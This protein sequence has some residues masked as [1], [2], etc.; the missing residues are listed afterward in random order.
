M[1]SNNTIAPTSFTMT[2][3]IVFIDS[4]VKD[5]QFLA[6]GILPSIEIVILKSDRDGIEQITEILSRRNN[7][8]SIHI[9]SHGSPG[10]LYIGNTQFSLDTLNKYQSQLKTWFSPSPQIPQ[11]PSL[12][13]YGCN[14]AAGDA[15]E[16]FITKLR[17]ITG[18]EIAA[19]TTPIGNANK[20]G[21]W[22]LDSQTTVIDTPLAFNLEAQQNYAGILA[23]TTS[24]S[25]FVDYNND[26]DLDV[27]D[28]PDNKAAE[29]VGYQGI[30]VIA[31]DA[32][33]NVVA[34][35]TTDADGNYTLIT[36]DNTPLRVEFD[37]LPEG[38]VGSSIAGNNSVTETFFIDGTAGS[39]SIA[40]LGIHRPHEVIPT[41]EISGDDLP[42]VD[43]VTVC[44]VEGIGNGAS[45]II[46]HD[47][48]AKGSDSSDPPAPQYEQLVTYDQI[49][50]VNGLAYH[51]Q[52][53]TLF[54]GSF[55]KR[56]S[57]LLGT[58][59]FINNG[60]ANDTSNDEN[61]VAYT[62][63]LYSIDRDTGNVTEFA[64]L[65]DV[66]DPRGAV[67]DSSQTYW[68]IDNGAD[69]NSGNAIFNAVGKTGL[70]DVE[71]S[72]DGNTLWTVNL[73]DN[74]LY[75][76]PVDDPNNP[77]PPSA[78][79]IDSFDVVT[80]ILNNG[81]DLGVNP[82]QNIRP[83]ALSTR[84]GLVY[85]G[86]VNSAQYDTNGDEGNTTAADMRAYVYAIDPDNP[87][88][89]PQKVLDIP[90]DYARDQ[91][92]RAGNTSIPADWNPW[93]SEYPNPTVLFG[94]EVSYPQPMLTDIDFDPEG[95]MILGFRDRFGDQMGNG[96]QP[97]S[98][99]NLLQATSAGDILL[100]PYDNNTDSWTI[101]THVTTDGINGAN[102]PDGE[103]FRNEFLEDNAANDSLQVH[104]ETAQ[105]GLTVVPGFT[106]VVTTAMDPTD[107]FQGGLEWFNTDEETGTFAGHFVNEGGLT[108]SG[109]EIFD[110]GD[111]GAAGKANGL[112]DLEFIADAAKV[113]IGNR[114]WFDLDKDGIQDVGEGGVDGVTVEL[115][116]EGG[117]RL[118][119]TITTNGQ[120]SFSGLSPLTDYE[121]RLVNADF[122]A[123]GSL[124][125]YEP[126]LAN[127]GTNDELDSDAA[128]KGGSGVPVISFQT[129][130]PGEND[131]S[132]DI[133]LTNNPPTYDYGDAPDA[134]SG[135]GAGNY[136]TTDSDNGARHIIA[137]GLTIGNDV[138]VDDGTLQ[139]TDADADLEQGVTFDET[140]QR[141][142]GSFTANV[143]VNLAT[144][145]SDDFSSGGYTGGI[146]WL[147]NWTER[148]DSRTT[149]T[150]ESNND[151]NA[152]VV[153]V[154]DG[155]L[156]IADD[157]T[158]IY[159]QVD[160]SGATGDAILTFNYSWDSLD[161]ADEQYEVI[162]SD[163]L[164]GN[165]TV[166]FTIDD[167]TAQ[168][169]DASGFA[170]INIPQQFLTSTT[171][172][173]IRKGTDSINL[174]PYDYAY[175]D[176]F[177]I[178]APGVEVPA[179]LA[180]WID[181]NQDGEFTANES[182]REDVT[183]S[184]TQS[185]TWNTFP[186]IVEGSTYARFRLSTDDALDTI[187]DGDSVGELRD[188]EV[189][190]YRL[191]VGRD[192]GDA[193]D[194]I[195][196]ETG[197]NPGE[198][199][200]T[201]ADSGASHGIIDGLSI[202]SNIDSDDGTL[203]NTDADADDTTNEGD[204][205]GVTFSTSLS[206]GDDSYTASIDVVNTTGQDA[207]LT[208]WID[209]DQ[210]GTFDTDERQ[211]IVFSESG[212]QNLIWDSLPGLVEGTTYAR[213]RLSNNFTTTSQSIVVVN[214]L[215]TED[216]DG[217]VTGWT[218][219][220]D[221]N[222]TALADAQGQ[223]VIAEPTPHNRFGDAADN[224]Q[225][226]A[227]NSPNALVTGSRGTNTD[228]DNSAGTAGNGVTA[229]GVTTIN[230]TNLPTL[231]TT[232]DSINL[233]LKYY[234]STNSNDN[235]FKIE[236]RRASDD[237]LISTLLDE[238]PSAQQTGTWTYFN[239][240]LTANA[241]EDT[242]LRFIAT[243]GG[244]DGIIEV[245]VDDIEITYN[246]T[247]IEQVPVDLAPDGALETGEVEDY[248]VNVGL[249]Y[250]DAPDTTAGEGTGDYQTTKANGGASHIIVN[251]LRIGSAI[252]ADD[253][254][255]QNDNAN[256]DDIN[257]TPDDEDGV[258]FATNL[259]VDDSSYSATVQ[260][261][262]DTGNDAKLVG[263]ID[264]NQDGVFALGES[265]VANVPT[266]SNNANVT[267]TWDDNP[268]NNAINNLTS[269]GFFGTNILPGTTYARF[270]LSTDAA[271][272]GDN[273]LGAAGDGEVEDYRL[274][275]GLDYGDARDSNP[276]TG[277]GNYNTLAT[278]NGASHIISSDL[279]IGYTTDADDGT[280]ENAP[281]T[282]DDGNGV[283]GQLNY[284][285]YSL[286]A[287]D[288]VN[289]IPNAG[290][291][292]FGTV[293]PS[294]N[295]V[296][297]ITDATQS[298]V[299]DPNEFG[300]RYTGSIFIA[301]PGTYTFSTTSDD[302]STLSINNTQVVN[303]DGRHGSRREEGTYTFDSAGYY[304]I[305]IEYFENIG[306]N[307]LIVRYQP[308]GVAT[309]TAIPADILSTNDEEGIKTFPTLRSDNTSYS[310]DVTVNNATGVAA[311]LIGWIDFDR[312]GTFDPNEAVTAPVPNN[313]S[314]NLGAAIPLNWSNIPD[315]IT[316]G[317]TSARFRL[318]TDP[319][320]DINS[321]TGLL[322]DGEVE[323][324][325][326][327]IVGVD[328]GDAPDTVTGA[329]GEDAGEYKTTLADG[330][331]SHIVV[332]GLK[333]GATVD[334]DRGTLQNL[335]ATADDLDNRG[336]DDDEDGITFNTLSTNNANSTYT[337]N[338]DFT[339]DT[340]S[341]AA[342]VGW[343]DFDQD[344]IFEP[345]E[346]AVADSDAA[347]AGVQNFNSQVFDRNTTLT[348]N[349]PAGI[350]G[351]T[352]Y[353]RFRISNDTT[354]LTTAFPTGELASGEVEDYQIFVEGG[355]DY[356]DAAFA[357]NSDRYEATTTG[358]GILSGLNI[359]DAIDDDPT[360][361]ANDTATADNI[362]GSN[363]EEG[364]TFNSTLKPT[365]T[366]YSVEVDVNIPP[367]LN[368]SDDFSSDNLT[369][370]T[371]WSND[372]TESGA[373][374]SGTIGTFEEQIV[375]I[376]AT[377]GANVSRQFD[378]SLATGDATLEFD[379][380]QFRLEAGESYTVRVDDGQVGGTSLD[381]LTIS[382]E[383]TTSSFV[384]NNPLTFTIPQALLADGT[385]T[386]SIVPDTVDQ[387]DANN[388][389]GVLLDNFNITAPVSPNLVGWIDFD[390]DGEFQPRE[391][392]SV[393]V[394]ESGT[395]TLNWPDLN[396]L[397]GVG[398][399]SGDTYARF[400]LST[401]PSLTVNTPT[402][403]VSNGEI[404]DY[405]ISVANI[406]YGDAPD[407]GTGT[408][409][410]NYQTTDD[411][412]G[413]SHII[414]S[415]LSI[416]TAPDGDSGTLA[417]TAADADDTIGTADEDGVSF[418]T[419]NLTATSTGYSI[420]VDVNANSGDNANLVGWIDFDRD[421]NFEPDEAS[422]IISNINANG[423]QTLTWSNLDNLP[424]GITSGTSYARIRLTTDDI[425]VNSS[426]GAVS[427]GEVQD[428]QITIEAV[429]YGD[430]P[431]TGAGTGT[432]NYE[433]TDK[434]GT[435][436]DGASH[437]VVDG[438]TIGTN[439][440][441]D[442]GELNNTAANADD[443]TETPDDE[444]GIVNGFST[445]AV[446][447][448]SYSVDVSVNN[449]SATEG[450]NLVGWIDFD[451][452]GIFEANEASNVISDITSNNGGTQTLNW[453][454]LNALPDGIVAGTSYVRLRYTT[455][456]ITTADSTGAATDGEVE[457]YQITIA[458]ADYGDAP[459]TG[460]GT[461]AGNYETTDKTGTANDGASHG[462][463]S[464]FSL[465]TNID[466]DSGT[467]QNAAATADD[468]EETDDED[469][470]A[471]LNALNINDTTYSVDVNVTNVP[472]VTGNLVGWIDF[473]GNGQFEVS[474]ASNVISDITTSGSQTLN[475]S[476]IN[477]VP[478]GIKAGSTYVRFRLSTDALTTADS[479][480][481]ATDGEVED[482][483]LTILGG[484]DFGD[485]D[486]DGADNYAATT[487]SHDIVDGL[488]IGDNIDNDPTP[489]ANADANADDNTGTSDEDG[490]TF[491]S[492]LKVTDTNYSVTVNVNNTTGNDAE[493][494]GWI[495]FNGNGTFEPSEAST[496][497]TV[498]SSGEVILNWT[499]ITGIVPGET[500][501]RFRLN[502][503][504][505]NLD[506]DTPTGD[507]SAGVDGGE[508]EDYK[509][510]VAE[511]DYGDAAGY[512]TLAT[513]TNPTRHGIVD[514]LSIGTAPDGDDGTL[515]NAA[516]DADDNTNTGSAD[517][518]DG[519]TLT[520]SLA[521][522]ST[523]YS[524]TVDVNSNPGDDA[525]LV[526]WIDFDG[527]GEFEASEASNVVSGINTDGT[528]ILT[529]NNLDS[530]PDGIIS[531][532]SYA[533]FRLSTDTLDAN[534]STGE[535]NDGEIEDYQL[536]IQD[537]DYGDAPDTGLGT[538]LNN[539]E[540]TD[541]TG[542][543]NDG[544]SHVVVSG[545]SLGDTI[546]GDDGTLQ[547]TAADADDNAPN[548]T[549]DEDGVLQFDPFPTQANSYAVDVDVINNLGTG[550]NLVGWID[551]DKDGIFEPYEASNVISNITSA[552]STQKLTWSGLDSLAGGDVTAGTTYVRLRLTTDTLTTAT[553]IGAAS[554]GEVEDYQITI[555]DIDFGDAPDTGA[556]TGA[557]N[558]ETTNKDGVG[559]DGPSH[560]IIDG[561][562]IGITPDGD[563]GE[564]QNT[565]ADAD[566][567]TNTAD[568]D[569]VT[570]PNTLAA[571]ST[572]YSMTVDV[573][574]TTGIAGGANLIGW[575]DF[576][577]DGQFDESEASA[578]I[579]G[580]NA[581]GTQT[582][583]W[584]DL[585]TLPGGINSGT[586]YVRLRYTT[587][588][589][590]AATSIG[591]A[592]DGEVQ[593]HQITI[594]DV[595]YGDA[596]DTGA[597]FGAGNYETTDKTGTTND[598]ASHVIVNGLSLGSQIDG[599]NGSLNN[600]VANADD[601]NGSPDDEDGVANFGAL[602]INDTS[603][604]IDVS[605]TNTTAIAGGANL[606][607]WIDFNGNGN[608]EASEASN[609]I[610]DITTSGT[611]QL[612]WDNGTN[613]LPGIK[614]GTTYV[615]LRYTTDAITTADSTGAASNGEVEDYR[616]TIEGGKDFGDATTAN[617]SDPYTTATTSH[618][619]VDGISLG[620][621]LDSEAGVTPNT[622]ADVD[623]VTDTKDE[624][625]VDFIDTKVISTSDD[626]YSVEVVVNS[627]P[628]TTNTLASD[629]FSVTPTAN[630]TNAYEAG[631]PNNTGTD[632]ASDWGG[633]ETISD[634]FNGNTPTDTDSSAGKIR[635][636]NGQLTLSDDD[637]G[638]DR[639]IDLS[640]ATG[641]VT[642]NFDYAALGIVGNAANNN[643][644]LLIRVSNDNRTSFTTI[645]TVDLTTEPT[646]GSV[647]A[648][649]P[650]NLYGTNTIISFGVDSSYTPANN[651]GQL[652]ENDGFT[653]DNVEVTETVPIDT[654]LVGWIDFDR[655]GT[656]DTDEGVSL[657][658]TDSTP[659]V[660]DGTTANTLTWTG[661]NGQTNGVTPGDTY[662]RFRL[663]TDSLTTD[664]TNAVGTATDGEIEDYALKIKNEVTGTGA[665]EVINSS[666]TS[667]PTT[668]ND[669]LIIGGAGQDT[670]TGGD[671]DDCFHFN[672]TSDG[673]DVI[674]DFKA[675]GDADKLDFS[676]LFATGGELEGVSD[677]FGTYVIA[678][679]AGSGTMIQVDFDASGGNFAKNVVYLEDYS[680]TI[681]ADDFIFQFQSK[682][683]F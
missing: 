630:T 491:T 53:E 601:N 577:G 129:G 430:A 561:L 238:T 368:A 418:P 326:I 580:I 218:V 174:G 37:G 681:T 264:F 104:A 103:F 512:E 644:Q 354:N 21:N 370:G 324:Y 539:Y 468:L 345:G 10:C 237:S 254:T 61:G 596:P 625:G 313:T 590:T 372:W 476:D 118:Q 593:D 617:G 453:S 549:D 308:P 515:Q 298:G 170:S 516:A 206:L 606:V 1:I 94:D 272:D 481:A 49:G 97:P 306:G 413:A 535:A 523:S 631:S 652:G 536:T 315:D 142:D 628:T 35:T 312:S 246:T 86:M 338:V 427:D 36:P 440:D 99:G 197:I 157:T 182:V 275:V 365:D 38:F 169:T 54:A 24:G 191:G 528:Q 507:L 583:N 154:I 171:T 366:E 597:G 541:K 62:S 540:T 204:E 415:G 495:D 158:E 200:T 69:G 396:T 178:T 80:N 305:E 524:V 608:F 581:N 520:N 424:D 567:T 466:G 108:V 111:T 603:Y 344:G 12:L 348:W 310:L 353:A 604:L 651:T 193:P 28:D 568:E 494:I 213:F 214:S 503:N 82:Q 181:F 151:P 362:T 296:T 679:T 525:N 68:E 376:A 563:S 624:D 231:P 454:N 148:D 18:A 499:G 19:S 649:I 638:A 156:R 522:N 475:W 291:D 140:L 364:V 665:G 107:T 332:D 431:D 407:T 550:A 100:A 360:P 634:I 645:E 470:V 505:A 485:A 260:V 369:G 249:D 611:Q 13:L 458:Q 152:G 123:G 331:A 403:S 506:V 394:T 288:S 352:T 658:T 329:N 504:P 277:Q 95:N 654:N 224:E 226:D 398:I 266:G 172:I 559:N 591:A 564:L 527:D 113:D 545:L 436:N 662:A 461:G 595:D 150:G 532:T 484:Q 77:T 93:V 43:L 189:E 92:V 261:T 115:Y 572:S 208:G 538:S 128:T 302:G 234:L 89:T 517:D 655:N 27:D 144:N 250:G 209:F 79:E 414:V 132:L 542:T 347:T 612:T 284:E 241:G 309:E 671:G 359:G 648:N 672:R 551:F 203:Q 87:N 177:N 280:A 397:P 616:I 228:V 303:N 251:N 311:T 640:G 276:G 464:G 357:D 20:G 439:I 304:P 120:Y 5:Y 41:T 31:Y 674:T 626:R 498:T 419:D 482:Y 410:G 447:A 391:G 85:V 98:G 490:V 480:G 570:I 574:N 587:D 508:V 130:A 248:V 619:V 530:L 215:Y 321:P 185:L 462:V 9:V 497:F 543:A 646:S 521:A 141:G 594:K 578:P 50:S 670:L 562:S 263:W 666:F 416:G 390:G 643:V 483:K 322:D 153:R 565:A 474:E 55:Y 588:A 116:D 420:T 188:G 195:V 15:G 287:P 83:F 212:T 599:D 546:D 102:D 210:S 598:G 383:N 66:L 584:T 635:V 105:G 423:T 119:T 343:I 657:S 566:D 96:V 301:T 190:D 519:V 252:D 384:A 678:T 257:N 623:D 346:G 465:G 184:G 392:T 227:Y 167:T 196:G 216:F 682:N 253:T 653:I 33:D 526:G 395:Q 582:L 187:E 262:N 444:D 244:N 411:D 232:A 460:A 627:V 258:S 400:R 161:N 641:T 162:V 2:E 661:I 434:L 176:N 441:G 101:E 614:A 160:L 356:G 328:Y 145:I 463:V 285:Y 642:L 131:F 52:S 600:T 106:E 477:N 139:N 267:L 429:D 17:H 293:D 292:A 90:L 469:G 67:N 316:A 459:D 16:E 46:I 75:R 387:E 379:Y 388:V 124:Q 205:D 432:G 417:N 406:D 558:Y 42:D 268:N 240:S 457:D 492:N 510:T 607:G 349:V 446:N 455:D 592:S 125:G 509:I 56:H 14:V 501:A 639:A 121:I 422:T 409:V 340:S 135:I 557:G 335:A 513:D 402:G 433:T 165:E 219:N 615:R 133:G 81:G 223:W 613:P 159:R 3:Q 554:D 471:S 194:V 544:A 405:K 456:A 351:G 163:N 437:V 571:N 473:N 336:D 60:N 576:N 375:S 448:D 168:G 44:Y 147:G 269:N 255:L 358:H 327:D 217:T 23:V 51:R 245:G 26:G 380:S 199:K 337:V 29:E 201:Q 408:G 282:A 220:P 278:D 610:S 6:T 233:S 74:K 137:N 426:T 112:G 265:V 320:L 412:N 579:T 211:S 283:V 180:G 72:E 110:N 22:Q 235:N 179:T 586:S 428:H 330:G 247:G 32:N 500:Y 632:W 334:A 73:N 443:I 143:D 529:W 467:L 478:D 450:A 602:N 389:E 88:A 63:V 361:T 149:A 202:G 668:A 114:I 683:I 317:I 325:T 323:D 286:T 488:S 109:L 290:A 555:Q 537:V 569:G 225:L 511:V 548:G 70:G 435:A 274:I 573:T 371:G 30:K 659:L 663:S 609:V 117:T 534:S 175:F 479:I 270:R 259:K 382:A 531:G 445:L 273:P 377:N 552:D 57:A 553:S 242:Y 585:D 91:V 438:L 59:D 319:D 669:D 127:Q 279:S 547:N 636:Q 40:N 421:G 256:A 39:S 207:L 629:D 289:D 404:E 355:T 533:R 122:L 136:Q 373:G 64:R 138:T 452:D 401:D 222:D 333:L 425:T 4:Q 675:N 518:E 11:Y 673:I 339:N 146:G 166:V 472:G 58:V 236:L 8:T 399:A 556:G 560:V 442:N 677:P 221:G 45:A 487:T 65:D 34:Q 230:S 281:A 78:S 633:F 656:F 660:T 239:S 314:G 486:P 84:D 47:Y 637:R 605:V 647:S 664:A 350:K 294:G 307:S 342:I 680:A 489:T 341:D 183:S 76:L 297:Q 229:D 589:I 164:D 271:F 393:T 71:L 198:Y 367:A 243:D 385:T 620:S 621:L 173:R 378:F 295:L 300:I 618:D 667:D 514:G 650:S 496:P 386:L 134:A 451:R 186:D 192:Y 374:G 155:R 363:D 381:V 48:D 126:T 7:F 622:A 25:V 449:P 493:L 676:D 318:S 575:I 299:A 502:N